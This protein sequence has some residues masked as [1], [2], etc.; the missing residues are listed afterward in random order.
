MVKKLCELANTKYFHDGVVGELR[1]A[2]NTAVKNEY[3]VDLAGCRFNSVN[4]VRE[5]AGFYSKL[6][7][8]ESEIPELDTILKHNCQVANGGA[9]LIGARLL[10]CT[11]FTPNALHDYLKTFDKMQ[12]YKLPDMLHYPGNKAL[13]YNIVILVSIIFPETVIDVGP[14]LTEIF[15]IVRSKWVNRRGPH[16]YYWEVCGS[17]LI[18]REVIDG[19]VYIPMEGYFTEEDFIYNRVVLPVEFGTKKIGRDPEFSDVL[20]NAVNV[21][22]TVPDDGHKLKDYIITAQEVY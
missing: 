16:R 22:T 14:N 19:R 10:D 11:Y 17:S 1:D 7:F 12:V 20:Q 9:K 3:I 15:K 6:Q 5:L 21:L 8:V 4:A 13:V 2:L 18:K